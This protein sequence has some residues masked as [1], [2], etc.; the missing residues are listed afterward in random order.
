MVLECARLLERM[1]SHVAAH[2]EE[3]RVFSPFMVAQYV[4]EAQK[5]GRA[6][7]PRGFLLTARDHRPPGGPPWWQLPRDCSSPT[8]PPRRPHTDAEAGG[9]GLAGSCSHP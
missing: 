7:C 4:V 2:A 8:G 5:V 1:Y 6:A 3:F 9:V